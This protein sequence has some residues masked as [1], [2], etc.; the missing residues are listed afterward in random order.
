ML[1]FQV[2]VLLWKK[3]TEGA[4]VLA[5][6]HQRKFLLIESKS[7]LEGKVEWEVKFVT[8]EVKN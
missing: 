7:L 6:F 1:G 3:A 8:I 4:F 2:G 5:M